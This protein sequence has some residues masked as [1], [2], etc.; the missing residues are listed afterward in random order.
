MTCSQN[1]IGGNIRS[2]IWTPEF[3]VFC[4]ADKLF[5]SH[6]LR[7]SLNFCK[8]R[9]LKVRYVNVSSVEKNECLATVALT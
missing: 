8:E 5:L 7:N 6:S 9:G 4:S 2:R 3:T 1:A